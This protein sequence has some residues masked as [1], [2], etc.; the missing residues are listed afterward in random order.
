MVGLGIFANNFIFVVDGGERAIRMSALKGLQSHVYGEGMHFKM[1][2]IDTI[3]RFE[4]RTQP[5]M[6]HSTTG[7]N[8]MQTV[9]VSMR[10]LYRPIPENLPIILSNIGQNYDERIIPSIGN[11]VLKSTIAQ[12]NAE[13]LIS[14]R[15]R[16]SKEIKDNL[17]K[18]A[19]EYS[20]LLDDVSITDLQFSPEFTAAI[21]QKQVA[22][23]M[24]ERSKFIVFKREEETK[25]AVLRAEGEAEAAKLVADAISE[26]GPGLIAMRKIEAAQHIA[27]QLKGS[28]NVTFLSGNTM[29]M[30]NLSGAGM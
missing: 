17:Q 30:I 6:I 12:Y 28:P 25:A 16:V 29:N 3:I 27:D 1:P 7:T 8:D 20:I 24:A 4:I 23:Q 21:E 10:L 11:E 2:F 22:Q 15:E 18:R 5:T 19:L 26:Y 13:Q 9:N 14:M